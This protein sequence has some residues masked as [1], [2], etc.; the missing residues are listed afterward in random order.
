MRSEGRETK[1]TGQPDTDPQGNPRGTDIAPQIASP[2]FSRENRGE[3][4]TRRR[5]HRA[6]SSFAFTEIS[7]EICID[8][9]EVRTAFCIC[10]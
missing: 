2:E 1:L 6:Q 7:E 10:N 8:A 4:G 3:Q 5:R 9:N